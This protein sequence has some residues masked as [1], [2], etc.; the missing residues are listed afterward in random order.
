MVYF[1]LKQAKHGDFLLLL[2]WVWNRGCLA[3]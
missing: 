1:V 3:T 2:R